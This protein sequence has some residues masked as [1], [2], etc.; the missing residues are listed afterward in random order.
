MPWDVLIVRLPDGTRRLEELP[1]GYWPP[2]FEPPLELTERL[3]AIP[4]LEVVDDPPSDRDHVP[5]AVVRTPDF[6][7][8][9]NLSSATRIHLQVEGSEASL[10]TIRAI[11]RALGAVAIDTTTGEAIDWSGDPSSGLRRSRARQELLDDVSDSSPSNDT[12]RRRRRRR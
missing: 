12:V 8:E 11:T 3:R 7:V 2:S 9:I 6:V 4:N 1:N 5:W 10:E